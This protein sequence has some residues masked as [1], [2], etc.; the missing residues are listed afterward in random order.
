ME[1]VSHVIAILEHTLSLQGRAVG[2]TAATPL[3]DHLPEL[4][5]L[6]AANVLAALED[7]FGIVFEPEDVDAGI[8]DTVGSLAAAVGRRLG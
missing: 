6:G 5:S 7:H 8:F 2:F 1:T 4:D 3:R